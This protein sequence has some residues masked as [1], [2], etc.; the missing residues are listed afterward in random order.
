M[1]SVLIRAALGAL[2]ATFGAASCDNVACVFGPG[3]CSGSHGGTSGVGSNPA[4]VP[5]DGA[6]IASTP[7]HVDNLFPTGT[8]VGKNS[9][10]VFV[11]NQS[12]SPTGLSSAFAVE[13]ASGTQTPL[14]NVAL[15][16]DNRVLVALP[17]L[18][19][20]A[21]T[22][23]T[24]VFRQGATIVDLVG[25]ALI[26]PSN[27]T[28]GT[29]TTGATDP[30]TPRVVMSW[31][32]NAAANQSSTP[33]SVVVF[34]RAMNSATVTAASFVVTV[35]GS[36]PP[37]N[38][39]P[40]PVTPIGGGPDTRAFR[41]KSVDAHG[42]AQSFGPS[43]PVTF[44]LS[45]TGNSIQD[46]TGQSLA[47]TA[48]SFTTAPFT[49]PTGANIT[50]MPT[51]AI[52]IHSISGPADLAIAVDLTGAASGDFLDLYMFGK[53]QGVPTNPPTA[54]LFREVALAPPFTSFTMT[55][56]EI[57]LV[58]TASPLKARFI[59]GTVAFAFLVRRGSTLSPVELLDVD[60]M[61][62]GVQSPTLDTVPPMLLGL[63]ASGM[64]LGTFVSD[65]R[66]LTMVGHAS[67]ALGG[68][69][70]STALGDNLTTP[71]GVPALTGQDASGLF[72][73]APV[74]VGI[75]DPASLPLAYT[76][77]I[78]DK[79]LNPATP[80]IGAFTQIG[81][82]GPGTALPGGNVTVSVYDAT[83]LAPLAGANVFTHED[84]AGTVDPIASGTTDATGAVTLSG[85]TAPGA[86][87][88]VTV[89][90]PGYDIFT[91]DGVP[92]SRLDVPLTPTVLASA[93]ASGEV[94]TTSSTVELATKDCAD[95][96][97]P[98]LVDSLF[99]VGNCSA[100]PT[101]AFFTCSFGPIP[102]APA[103]IGAAAALAVVVPT[104]PFQYSPATFL[105]AYQP[106]LPIPPAAPGG[107]SGA[108]IAFTSALDDPTLD[109]SEL[110][111]DVAPAP[112][113]STAN[114]PLFTSGTPR[115]RLEAKTPGIPGALTTGQGVAYD[116]AA[117][118]LPPNTWL[119]HAA[120]AGAVETIDAPPAH[121]LGRLVKQG[122]VEVPLMLRVEI[123]DSASNIGGVRSALPLSASTL[124]PPAS[125]VLANPAVTLNP[126]FLSLD[127]SFSDVLPDAIGEPGLY[128][129]TLTD[130]NGLHWTI[131][132]PDAPDSAGP[133]AIAHLPFV[134]PTATLPLAP[135]P[136]GCQVSAFA[137]PTFD[138]A[139]F[140]WTDVAREHDLYSHAA[141]ASFTP[142]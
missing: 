33:D 142:P 88:I 64:T 81:A 108:T 99:P 48:I 55:A 118:M 137:W 96:R 130:V 49:A 39:L 87:T 25:R 104:N 116:D 83:T 47:P 17:L 12:V 91:F 35:N 36:P 124:A 11:F 141:S 26:V 74:H 62:D 110:P 115:V 114:Y 71:G 82:S 93:S 37:F 120:Y 13:V 72:A 38:P 112:M 136:L 80:V 105:K 111:V 86:E 23:Y 106:S 46:T 84:D 4:T 128:R 2:A 134:S 125:A 131:F 135:G 24:V 89:V 121:T 52:G 97:S 73:A 20:T 42:V 98:E 101:G 14:A 90:K 65:V 32:M 43:A 85:A 133:D 60:A 122:T 59:D 127:L 5:A 103:R 53:A 57:D 140:L 18:P 77:T 7:P 54:A 51:D 126:G 67:E 21:S 29:F 79:A 10:I 63:G 107:I 102:I 66:D 40:T 109:P 123:T 1:D 41:Y 3:N 129:V 56:A 34:D 95:S 45:P 119:V 68:A 100:D 44:N 61:T 28:V 30:A 6:F 27:G 50:S 78:Y 16:A 76:I 22:E 92:T 31:P 8:T 69:V 9:P 70:V 75:V 19:L 132:R 94:T 117:L 113:F 138:P 139:H 15:V 58:Q